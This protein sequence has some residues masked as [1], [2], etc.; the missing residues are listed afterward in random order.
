MIT[1]HEL[2]SGLIFL[3]FSI[4]F[5]SSLITGKILDKIVLNAASLVLGITFLRVLIPKGLRQVETV[6]GVFV[7]LI[8]INLFSSLILFVKRGGKEI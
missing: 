8:S 7:I 3:T 6:I 5:V 1:S 2:V 4:V